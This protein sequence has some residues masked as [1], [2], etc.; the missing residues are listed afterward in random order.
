[1][2]TTLQVA[3]T[4]AATLPVPV[5][6]TDAAADK[7]ELPDDVTLAEPT[8]DALDDGLTL[9]VPDA[10]EVADALAVDARLGVPLVAVVDDAL[11]DTL[12]DTDGLTDAELDGVTLGSRDFAA[13]GVGEQ[14]P[15]TGETAVSST[16]IH[17]P[18]A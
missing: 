11:D 4:V 2:E 1:V 17:L 14:D 10:P 3:D 6:D 12:T 7:L 5:T 8:D 18:S 15:T 13:E 9:G 16:H